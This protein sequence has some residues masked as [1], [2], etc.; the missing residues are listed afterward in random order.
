[1]TSSSPS[2]KPD[3][4]LSLTL[5]SHNSPCQA[6]KPEERGIKLIQLLL[7]CA[8]HASS[9]NLHRAD[10]CL[11]RISHLASV[12]GDSMQRLASRF[13]SALAVRLVRRWPGL[14]KAL[15]HSGP[16]RVEHDQARAVFAQAFPYL[17]FTYTI[18][19]RTLIQAMSNE[20]VIHVVDLGSG[21]QNYGS[22]FSGAL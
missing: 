9:G 4:T 8:N 6:L 10:A 19:I 3:V 11:S 18:I 2:L 21:N 17:G 16:T 14:F 22:Q 1:M 20:R 7:A 13:A 15:N 5:P 12:S